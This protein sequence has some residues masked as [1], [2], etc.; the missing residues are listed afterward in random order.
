[1]DQE[2]GSYRFERGTND[3]T[4]CRHLENYEDDKAGAKEAFGV[5]AAKEDQK[6]VDRIIADREITLS[7]DPVGRDAVNMTSGGDPECLEIQDDTQSLPDRSSASS[8][9]GQ[10]PQIARSECSACPSSASGMTRQNTSE[11]IAI[12]SWCREASA[13]GGKFSQ[14]QSIKVHCSA[15]D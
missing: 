10:Q 7:A 15:T 12:S 13:S 3:V 2:G 11:W 14:K 4:E 1:M 6:R 9:R 5:L 8:H